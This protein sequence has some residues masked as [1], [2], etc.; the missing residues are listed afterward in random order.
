[1]GL[2]FG[3]ENPKTV[4]KQKHRWLFRIPDV[5]AQGIAALPPQKAAR[6]SISFKEIEV[7]HLNETIYYPGKPE[8]KTINLT[9]YDIKCRQSP[10]MDWL[11]KLYDPQTGDYQFIISDDISKNFKVDANLELLDSCGNCLEMWR[12][13]NCWPQ[14]VDF[15]ELDMSSVDV[16]VAEITLRY[17]RAYI[18]Q[19]GD[20]VTSSGGGGDFGGGTGIVPTII[21]T[22]PSI[23]PTPIS[24]GI[25]PI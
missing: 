23:V 14:Q 3:L 8:F 10:V 22:P 25:G 17:D 7:Q 18:I 4:F 12:Y 9:L 20:T 24:I 13:E 15:Q 6:P 19:C 21:V 5:S 16:L 2:Q 1:M 11:T